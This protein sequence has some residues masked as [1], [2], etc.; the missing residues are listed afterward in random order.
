MN[1]KMRIKRGSLYFIHED[2]VNRVVRAKEWDGVKD[3]VLY[4]T[5]LASDIE[6]DESDFVYLEDI[7]ELKEIGRV[8]LPLYIGLRYVTSSMALMI[9]NFG[10][11]NHKKSGVGMGKFT[12]IAETTDGEYQAVITA[13]A[14]GRSIEQF[15]E[16]WAECSEEVCAIDFVENPVNT[17]EEQ[18]RLMEERGWKIKELSLEDKVILP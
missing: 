14:K 12:M 7:K 6:N 4:F 16:D 13:E 17:C 2:G 8:D 10:T 3:I 5:L 11:F 18:Y 15:N 1:R 9:R